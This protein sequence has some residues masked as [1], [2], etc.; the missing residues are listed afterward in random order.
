[1]SRVIG[2]FSPGD[3]DSLV[4]SAR[5][6]ILPSSM[7]LKKLEALLYH[8][9]V[10]ILVCPHLLDTTELFAKMVALSSVYGSSQFSTHL[11]TLGIVRIKFLWIWWFWNNT[12]FYF[13]LPLITKDQQSFYLSEIYVFFSADSLFIVLGMFPLVCWT[14]VLLI[15]G[16]FI[17]LKC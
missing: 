4:L 1:M 11:T 7:D 17:Y 10:R 16:V 5:K 6:K 8:D 14:Y 13:D 3:A 12:E 2:S 9:I 15:K